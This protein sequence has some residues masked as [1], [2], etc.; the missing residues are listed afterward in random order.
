[1]VTLYKF[2]KKKRIIPDYLI[3]HILSE[4]SLQSSSST[5]SLLIIFMMAL[6]ISPPI[7]FV[8]TQPCDERMICGAL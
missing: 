5:A 3:N 2:K 1:M 8:L 7:F 4:L 6:S